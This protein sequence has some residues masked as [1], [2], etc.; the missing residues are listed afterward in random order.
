MDELE[1]G[2]KIGV[3]VLVEQGLGVQDEEGVAVGELHALEGALFREDLID[4]RVEE[5]VGGEECLSQAALDGR[6]ELLLGRG[7]E[8]GK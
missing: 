7:G 2:E 6:L 8:T 5:W 3:G 4:V 1:V